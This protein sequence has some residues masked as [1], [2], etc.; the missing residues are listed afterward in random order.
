MSLPKRLHSF[1][2][3]ALCILG[4]VQ[5]SCAQ[6]YVQYCALETTPISVEWDAG[7]Q[8]FFSTGR[9]D[10]TGKNEDVRNL[11]S[12]NMNQD[13]ND[14][15]TATPRSLETQQW[16]AKLCPC[17]SSYR[18]K[19]AYCLTLNGENVCKVPAS[20]NYTI[21]CYRN[22][23]AT[24]F[25][26]NAWPV[27]VLWL[28][29]MV[30]YMV[31]TANG[32]LG[33]KYVIAK[34]CCCGNSGWAS[35]R[36]LIDEILSREAEARQRFQRAAVNRIARYRQQDPVTYILKTTEYKKPLDSGAMSPGE[37]T[38]PMTPDSTQS[39]DS[40]PDNADLTCTPCNED[41]FSEY[42]E[43]EETCTI[44]SMTIED[45]DRI[46]LLPCDHKFHVDCLKEWIKRKNVCPLCQ[47]PDIAREKESPNNP[48]QY[49]GNGPDG[50]GRELQAVRRTGVQVD[51][52]AIRTG[53]GNRR[54][55]QVVADANVQRDLFHVNGRG[56][57]HT[58]PGRRILVGDA[59][60]TTI[61]VVTRSDRETP[62]QRRA[63]LNSMRQ[64]FST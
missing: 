21:E 9:K 54:S 2:F 47:V 26:R 59:G 4:T 42:D 52:D 11:R 61:Q 3:I 39:F 43:N 32:R 34:I 48:V 64:A 29:A 44:C 35:N 25:T 50:N 24:V 22:T 14:E 15:S 19:P 23:S 38:L 31:S 46:G 17:A 12:R 16:Q 58:I 5:K 53:R 55:R 30:L 63:R 60:V 27:A 28:S 37:Q 62:T 56:R 7:L 33:A 51:A 45:G 1:C 40:M 57:G 41:D 36:N 8:S 49:V 18:D 10:A 20:S 13:T 6:Q